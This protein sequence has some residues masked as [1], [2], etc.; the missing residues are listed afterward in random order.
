MRNQQSKSVMTL[1]KPIL[2]QIVPTVNQYPWAPG[3]DYK[4]EM[5]LHQDNLERLR[6]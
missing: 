5:R 3:Y 1:D 6:R 4:E 2:S